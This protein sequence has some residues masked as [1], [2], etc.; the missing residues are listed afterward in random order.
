MSLAKAWCGDSAATARKDFEVYSNPLHAFKGGPPFIGVDKLKT[1]DDL[2]T[3]ADTLGANIQVVDGK[4][5][6]NEFARQ[7]SEFEQ[8][9]EYPVPRQEREDGA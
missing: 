4:K 9:R 8:D 2:N 1:F 3:A 6:R 5:S 7:V